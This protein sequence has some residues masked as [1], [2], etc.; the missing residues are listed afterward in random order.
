MMAPQTSVSFLL[1]NSSA[2]AVT[3]SPGFRKAGQGAQK[4]EVN[5]NPVVP[6]AHDIPLLLPIQVLTTLKAA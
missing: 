5:A 3:K 2:E 4:L 1:C 6:M